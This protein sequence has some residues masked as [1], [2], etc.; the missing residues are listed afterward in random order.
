MTALLILGAGFP[1]EF[2]LPTTTA[3]IVNLSLA[4]IG[5]LILAAAL[6]LALYALTR[7]DPVYDVKP[8]LYDY[9]TGLLVLSVF[10]FII[11]ASFSVKKSPMQLGMT[12]L[13]AIGVTVFGVTVLS[14]VCRKRQE[15]LKLTHKQLPSRYINRGGLIFILW[16]AEN[17]KVITS[18]FDGDPTGVPIWSGATGYSGEEIEQ[19]TDEEFLYFLEKLSIEAEFEK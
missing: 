7:K 8:T 3:E 18:I 9:I 14:A 15:K 19:F 6:I 1:L 16:R 10:I 13:A 5:T 11:V 4:V 2:L 12:I 17:G